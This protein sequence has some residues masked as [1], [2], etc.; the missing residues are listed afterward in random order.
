MTIEKSPACLHAQATFR[1]VNG[2]Y[3]DLTEW[4]LMMNGSVPPMNVCSPAWADAEQA[5]DEA[6]AKGDLE[7]VK[8]LCAGFELRAAAFFDKHRAALEKKR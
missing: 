8:R 5:I 4:A 7:E 3:I 2:F 6:I 1:R